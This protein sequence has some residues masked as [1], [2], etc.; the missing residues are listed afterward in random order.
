MIAVYGKTGPGAFSYFYKNGTVKGGHLSGDNPPFVHEE[1]KKI[2]AKKM[3]ELFTLAEKISEKYQGK[4]MAPEPG[5]EG[6]WVLTFFKDNTVQYEL[7]WPFPSE[8][9]DT[10]VADFVSVLKENNAG[11][12]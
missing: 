6:Y 9:P 5:R 8:Y 1:T 11:H 12:W 7:M 4:I 3:K 2:Q 10:E